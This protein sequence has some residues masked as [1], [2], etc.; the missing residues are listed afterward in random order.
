MEQPVC[1]IKTVLPFRLLHLSEIYNLEALLE[2]VTRSL[3]IMPHFEIKLRHFI[4]E[5]PFSWAYFPYPILGT[6]I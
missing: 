5:I 3:F 6:K 2:D 1:F 4:M